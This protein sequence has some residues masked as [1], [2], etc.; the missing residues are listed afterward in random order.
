MSDLVKRLRGRAKFLFDGAERKSP[1]LFV[2]AADRI[3]QLERELRVYMDAAEGHMVE[4]MRATDELIS[5]EA[6]IEALQAL[7]AAPA[8]KVKPLVWEHGKKFC[9]QEC[10]FADTE[11]GGWMMVAYY[12]RGGRWAHTDP[13]GTDSED[14]WETRDDCQAAANA[15]YER[16]ILS[17]LDV[18]SADRIE[19]LDRELAIAEKMATDANEAYSQA[20]VSMI[21]AL[22]QL[23]AEKARVDQYR[24][25]LSNIA[26][27]GFSDDPAVAANIARYAVEM[28]RKA[29]GL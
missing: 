5:R 11:F 10:S 18:Q 28:A 25:A 19:E 22:D 1:D 21:E 12:G 3:D 9:G 7:P 2:E 14:D 4:R 17:A 29:R 15:D 16:R 6:E 23:A 20:H 8:V 13:E 24:D 27:M 26:V